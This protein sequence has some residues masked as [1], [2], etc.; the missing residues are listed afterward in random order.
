MG[1]WF[2]LAQG[3]GAITI[4]FEFASYQIKDQR[5]YLLCT[6][7]AN[8]FWALMFVFMG[9]ETKMSSVLI[10]ILAAGFGTLRGLIFWWIFA[11]KTKGR[12]IAGRVVLLTS[13][14]ILMGSAIFVITRLQTTTQIIIQSLGL[15]CGLLFVIGQYLPS[16]HYLRI[17]TFMY[18]AMVLVGSTPLNLLDENGVGFWNYTGI[19]IEASK[20]LSVIVFYIIL[21]HTTKTKCEP[22][23]DNVKK[24]LHIWKEKFSNVV[25]NVSQPQTPTNP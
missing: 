17:F 1:I 13:L 3:M 7:V 14:A 4:I 19:A 20:I 2:Y 9:I 21:I 24:D 18:A 10:M 22:C 23:A 12:K 11:K 15:F 6:S 25:Q 8:V 5:K 16:K